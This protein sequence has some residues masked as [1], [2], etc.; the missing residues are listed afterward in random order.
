MPRLP[1]VIIP[2]RILRTPA[3]PVQLAELGSPAMQKLID[4]M[5]ET[6]FIA[7]GIGLAAPQIDVS[8]RLIVVATKDGATAYVNPKITK[9]SLWKESMEEG[10]LSIPGVFGMVKRYKRITV[11]ALDRHGKPVTVVAEGLFARII[12]HEVDHIDGILFTTRVSRYTKGERPRI[13]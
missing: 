7:D 1:I 2:N 3:A 13:E 8:K 5:V 6:M 10:C 12:Q 4:D 9:H 11:E